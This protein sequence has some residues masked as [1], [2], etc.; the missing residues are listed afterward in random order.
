MKQFTLIFIFFFT[1]SP[2]I[3][4]SREIIPILSDWKFSKGS[5]PDAT[6][7]NFDDSS[8]ENISIPH[9]WA[10]SGP[11][12]MDGEGS[13][14]KLPWKGEGWYRKELSISHEFSGKRIYMIFD[15]IMA[16][17]KIYLNGKLVGEWD[18]GYNSF[19][20]DITDFVKIG[21]ANLLSIHVDT[22]Q[23]KSRWYPGA[24]I[25]RK[26]QMVAV[27]PVHVDIWGT[28]VTTPIIKSHYTDVRIA[29]MINNTS[30]EP[31]NSV[32][33]ENVI[34]S[35]A[36]KEVARETSYINLRPGKSTAQ[37]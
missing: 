21:E 30:N 15:G 7:K 34:I 24:G 22:R 10:I 36:G 6:L 29:H 23:H 19:Y 18:Y 12:V 26:I 16:F 11:F 37:R 28:Y 5:H 3:S 20:L 25:F 33:V 1:F 17:P 2:I 35:P 9:D 8:W 4:F 27:N 13:T 14:A 32:K 31:R